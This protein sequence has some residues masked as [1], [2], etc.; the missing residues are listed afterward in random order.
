MRLVVMY[1][2][3]PKKDNVIH[4]HVQID[5]NLLLAEATDYLQTMLMQAESSGIP[6]L[7][8]LSGG[9]SLALLDNLSVPDDCSLLTL[10]A[11]DERF[12]AD[13][14]GRNREQI[15]ARTRMQKI[16]E[17]G[18]TLLDWSIDLSSTVQI[19]AA[20]YQK[21]LAQWKSLHPTGKFVA[22]I[23]IGE[24]GHTFGILPFSSE[25][26][27]TNAMG[28]ALIAGYHTSEFTKYPDRITPT[29]A[30]LPFIDK[31]LIYCVGEK[32]CSVLSDLFS[33]EKPTYK[34]PAKLLLELREATLFTNCPIK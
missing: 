29:A 27:Y 20:N 19:N 14:E 11:L 25:S 4:T 16:L 6:L 26:E 30:F 34:M 12:T 9:S 17:K 7:V 2:E 15:L 3:R 23:G 1:F 31:A 24:D 18:A 33:K 5:T 22:T 28:D 21:A 8:L 10:T 13:S 32:K